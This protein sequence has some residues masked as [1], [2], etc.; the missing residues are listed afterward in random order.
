MDIIV[1]CIHGFKNWNRIFGSTD[2]TRNWSMSDLFNH[3]IWLV[4]KS[5]NI[6][7][8]ELVIYNNLIFNI[9]CGRY[10][11]KSKVKKMKRRMMQLHKETFYFSSYLLVLWCSLVELGFFSF[12]FLSIYSI[13][14]FLGE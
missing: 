4:S 9:E 8:N 2:W 3:K 6:G 1:G 7:G 5:V 13:T 11:K 12:L 10:F 14:M